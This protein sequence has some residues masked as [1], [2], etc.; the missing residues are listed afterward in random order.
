M[1][2]Y[3][4]NSIFLTFHV[5]SMTRNVGNK[6]T[7]SY[8]VKLMTLNV[9]KSSFL[10]CPVILKTVNAGEIWL[11]LVVENLLLKKQIRNLEIQKI[12]W[13]KKEDNLEIKLMRLLI[14]LNER[15]IKL[16]NSPKIR[17]MR[18]NNS[19]KKK[20]NKQKTQLHQHWEELKI[21]LLIKQRL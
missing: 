19:Q 16:N 6:S 20:L 9:G 11:L 2:N 21:L 1:T 7:L 10:L 5:K 14:L 15:L 17:H 3:V 12:L 4:G 8:L 18:L 13:L